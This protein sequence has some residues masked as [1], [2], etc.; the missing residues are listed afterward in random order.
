MLGPIRTIF[1]DWSINKGNP[2]ARLVLVSFRIASLAAGR[3]GGKSLRW[4][5]MLPYLIAYRVGVEW[6]LGIE[7]PYKLKAGANLRLF[8]GCALVV[9]DHC[10][11]GS[12][13]TLRHSTTLGN[14]AAGGGCPV[15]GDN[16]DIGSN[17]VIL[18]DISICQGSIIGAGAVIT[19]SV[20]QPSLVVGNPGRVIRVLGTS[21]QHQG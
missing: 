5:L 13:V 1:C 21:S 20:E 7:L 16:V 14:K 8:H 18:G 12:H 17:A 9:N 2:K 4:F 6:F 11:L 10:V 15:I 3:D 19:K